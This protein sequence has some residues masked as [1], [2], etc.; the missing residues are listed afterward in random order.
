MRLEDLGKAL[1]ELS[2]DIIGAGLEVHKDLGPGLLENAYE[3]CL[4]Y[5]LR[6][7]GLHVLRQIPMPVT[8]KGIRIDV[9]FRI[10]LLVNEAIVVEVKAVTKLLPVHDAQLLSYLRLGDHQLG[11][12]FNFNVERLKDGMRRLVNIAVMSGRH[13][14]SPVPPSPS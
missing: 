3:T 1:N 2:S 14:T 5:E 12:L 10:D 11:L 9:G 4:D 13:R 6:Q 7:R 8:Y